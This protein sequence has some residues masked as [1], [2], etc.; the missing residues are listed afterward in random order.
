MRLKF[1]VATLTG[2]LFTCP[3][4]AQIEFNFSGYVVDFPAYERMNAVLSGLIGVDQD[5]FVNVAR[6]RLRPTLNLW[7]GAFLSLEYEVNSVYHSSELFFA[8][9]SGQRSGQ[10]V[11]LTWNPVNTIHHSILHFV[12]RLYFRQTSDVADLTIG[13]QRIAWGTG[14]VWNPTDLFNPISPTNISRIEKDGV[15]AITAKFHFGSFTD[16]S[17]VYNPEKDFERSNVG[18][19]F[20]TNYSGYDMSLMGGVFDE[21]F[22]IG[23]DF[24]GNLFDAG[25]RGEGIVSVD[26]HDAGL[27]FVK[28]IL[29]IDDQLSSRLYAMVEYHFNGEGKKNK[30]E[31]ELTRLINGEIINLSQHYGVVEA[32]YLIHPLVTATTMYMRNFNDGSGYVGISISYSMTQEFSL[33]VGGQIFHGDDYD[34]YWYYP[35]ALYLRADLYF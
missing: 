34:E 3:L 14:R 9:P 7:T 25:L 4:V 13:R 5:Q 11:D 17:V 23:A 27:D 18:L 26:R 22:V 12:D 32:T 29:G 16:L 30:L 2:F 8:E 15:D 10:V 1:F 35:N 20:R 28:F 24:A 6:I 19:R 33:S 31:Y 21:R